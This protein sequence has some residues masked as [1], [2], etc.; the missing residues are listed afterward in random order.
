MKMTSQNSVDNIIA[1]GSLQ[2]VCDAIGFCR[3]YSISELSSYIK[4]YS[5]HLENIRDEEKLHVKGRETEEMIFIYKPTDE[6]ENCW[7]TI[8][9]RKEKVIKNDD[10]NDGTIIH[11]W[12]PVNNA[13]FFNASLRIKPRG[14]NKKSYMIPLYVD[15]PA[16]IDGDND[17]NDI[18]YSML[19]ILRKIDLEIYRLYNP[20]K[21]SQD[22]EKF[23]FPNPLEELNIIE[24]K[25]GDIIKVVH[26]I[27][28][29]P[30]KE[31]IE[32]MRIEKF[33]DLDDIDSDTIHDIV[34]QEY[35]FTKVPKELVSPV[36]Q[37][38]FI[39]KD[40]CALI[41]ENVYIPRHIQT[42]NTPINQL[43]KRC[44]TRILRRVISIETDL[45]NKKHEK[46]LEKKYIEEIDQRVETCKMLHKRLQNIKMYQFFGDVEERD[47]IPYSVFQKG[48]N[49]SRFYSIYREL[50]ERPFFQDNSDYLSV[51]IEDV[52]VLYQKSG[53][54][55]IFYILGEGL[56]G[57]KPIGIPNALKID[58]YSF[59]FELKTG[60][61]SLIDLYNEKDRD[62]TISLFYQKYRMTRSTRDNNGNKGKRRIAPDVT[63]EIKIKGKLIRVLT[64]DVKYRSVLDTGYQNDPENPINKLHMYRDSMAIR[65]PITGDYYRITRDVYVI[66]LGETHVDYLSERMKKDAIGGIRLIPKKDNIEEIK[67]PFVEIIQNFINDNI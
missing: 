18:Y 23:K 64:F 44:I 3:T 15:I 9:K 57:W 2:I 58:K 67:R 12:R 32:I 14:K 30:N 49:Y 6:E 52:D 13:G 54:V 42:F 7:V 50:M 53:A 20:T 59:N 29:N 21:V 35:S 28:R 55:L 4:G 60:N 24:Q 48:A 16:K 5:T 34:T 61:N 8:Y 38:I 1:N 39:E 43:L 41:P 17:N 11:K 25:V 19:N 45:E 33:S 46:R 63:I 47:N 36:F 10:T 27:S 40:E 37:N 62:I 66:Y 65:D 22:V 26:Q 56:P 51:P 31:L